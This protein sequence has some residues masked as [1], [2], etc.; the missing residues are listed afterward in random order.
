MIITQY[1]FSKMMPT[2]KTNNVKEGLF[3]SSATSRNVMYDDEFDEYIKISQNV[4][5]KLT[6]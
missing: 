4:G 6:T 3:C 5:P 2:Y 1:H